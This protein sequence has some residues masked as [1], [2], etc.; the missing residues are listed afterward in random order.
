ML[1]L[2]WLL[3]DS[4]HLKCK[5]NFS[6]LFHHMLLSCF[7]RQDIKSLKFYLVQDWVVFLVILML[8][9]WCNKHQS[10]LR[11]YQMRNL[12]CRNNQLRNNMCLWFH[13]KLCIRC[14]WTEQQQTEITDLQ[15]RGILESTIDVTYF[16]LYRSNWAYGF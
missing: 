10:Q 5:C 6:L 13:W 2:K 16:Y 12:H 7:R 15:S 11:S 3:K 9:L 1:L 4:L 8:T 14:S